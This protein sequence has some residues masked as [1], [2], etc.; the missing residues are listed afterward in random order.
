M[1]L[2]AKRRGEGWRERGRRGGER[3]VRKR[4]NNGGKKKGES[5]KGAEL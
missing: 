2:K 5:E 1:F 4:G 3:Q